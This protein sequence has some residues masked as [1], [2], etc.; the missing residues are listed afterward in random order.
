MDKQDA[1]TRTDV[2]PTIKSLYASSNNPLSDDN[3]PVTLINEDR[4]EANDVGLAE[5][6]GVFEEVVEDA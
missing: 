5:G 4:L 2:L 6:L 1:E 3:N